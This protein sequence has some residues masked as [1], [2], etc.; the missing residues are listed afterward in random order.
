MPKHTAGAFHEPLPHYM[1]AMGMQGARFI[2]GNDGTGAGTNDGGKAGEQ[3]GQPGTQPAGDKDEQ[4]QE[5]GKKALEAERKR[6]DE[7]DKLLKAEQAKTKAA[8]DA[9]LT[10]AEREANKAKER[11]AEL[12]QLRKDNLRLQALAENPVPAKYQVLVK[13]D[14]KEE[15]EASA[16]LIAELVAGAPKNDDNGDG[17]EGKRKGDPVPGSGTGKGHDGKSFAAGQDLYEQR[18][19]KK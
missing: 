6:A 1:S 7:L 11:D 4:L 13:G 17:Q 18:H 14:T 5:P 10:E 9:K 16:A 2:E 3:G 15:L 8:E 19:K 12:E